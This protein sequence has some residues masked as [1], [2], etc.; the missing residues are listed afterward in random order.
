MRLLHGLSGA[1]GQLLR[2]DRDLLLVFLHRL[3]R[4]VGGA[5]A[6]VGGALQLSHRLVDVLAQLG[7]AIHQTTELGRLRS[8]LLEGLLR[9]AIRRLDLIDRA[10]RLRHDDLRALRDGDVALL[11]RLLQRP[12]QLLTRRVEL[13][14]LVLHRLQRR[15]GLFLVFVLFL[16]VLLLQLVV[17]GRRLLRV[18]VRLADGIALGLLGRG[19][20]V[21]A[22]LARGVAPH[23]DMGDHLGARLLRLALELFPELV[24][25]LLALGERL[26]HQLLHLL[27]RL[28]RARRLVLLQVPRLG[29]RLQRLFQHLLGGLEHFLLELVQDAIHRLLHLLLH[30]VGDLL[31]LL[32][33]L[34]PDLGEE[35]LRLGLVLLRLGE[36]VVAQLFDGLDDVG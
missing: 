17:L 18:L 34:V 2:L 14:V 6:L 1:G 29:R 33:G 5:L 26:L 36:A 23:R 13:A 30:V 27:L 20:G 15:L 31:Q 12:L 9:L 28:V 10:A 22:H 3:A 25:L 7:D 8:G 35:L 11:D 24:Q 16:V 4:L 19:V 32:L 21:V